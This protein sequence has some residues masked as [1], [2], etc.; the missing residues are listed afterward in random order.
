MSIWDTNIKNPNLPLYQSIAETIRKGIQNG[1]LKPGDHLP[2]HRILADQ[3]G[4]TVGTVARGYNL[5][6]S[7][8]LVHGEIGRGT[9]VS[10]PDRDYAHVPLDMNGSYFDLG[11]I[12]PTSTTDAALRKLAY[13]DT[14]KNIGR[15]WKN[16]AFIG[17][18]PEFG[19]AHY[20]EA[21]ACWIARLGIEADKDEVLL[22]AG[23]QE[24]IHLLLTNLT[25]PGDPILVEEFTHI[26]F[27]ELA[28]IL[29]LK[30]IG[31]SMDDQGIMPDSLRAV[32]KQSQAR[33]LF[34][35]PTYNSP[36]TAIM[37]GRRREQIID[38]SLENNLF[39]IENGIFSNF[40]LNP[41]PPIAVLC[42]EQTAYVSSLSFCASPEIRVGYLKTL[43]KNIPKLKATKRALAV[44]GSMI[45]AE[46]ATHWINTGVMEKLIDWQIREIR[47]RAEIAAGIL[48]GLDYRYAPDGMF[49]WLNLPEP[50]RVTDFAKAAEDRNTIVMESERFVIGR[51]AAPHAIRISLTS[52]QTRELLVEGLNIIADLVSSPSKFNPLV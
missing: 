2:P 24:A 37:S 26:S 9:I 39:I 15:R 18:P 1:D 8:G 34:I 25:D 43:K 28:S 30:M 21:G 27:K 50:W 12:K 46:I 7:W 23:A 10:A 32:T 3:V 14:L 29:N 6:A 52:A 5:A 35:T 44:S 48:E 36:T 47:T 4:V 38:I 31:I 16:K 42:P 40:A 20:R 17:F 19:L 11:I 22:T 13:E 51:G 49:I 45:S 33:V 41:P